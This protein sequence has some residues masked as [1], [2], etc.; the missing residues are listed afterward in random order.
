MAKLQIHGPRGRIDARLERVAVDAPAAGDWTPDNL[1][2]DEISEPLEADDVTLRADIWEDVRVLALFN[3]T[4]GGSE[5]VT[6]QALRAV[7]VEGAA[8]RWI[9]LGDPFV[10]TPDA[11]SELVLAD[12]ADLGFRITDLTLDTSDSVT[13]AV[14]AGALAR[15]R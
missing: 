3:G 9:P 12:G 10:L 13:V 5:S 15:N 14:L 2:A 7:W 6:L 4:N 8:R 1:N 11:D